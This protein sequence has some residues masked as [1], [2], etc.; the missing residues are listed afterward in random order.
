MNKIFIISGP[1]AVGKTSIAKAIIKKLP[2][3]Q[4]AVSFTTRQ[5]RAGTAEDKIMKYVTEKKFKAKIKKGDFIEWAKVHN[6]LY[7]TDK[8]IFS[9]LLKK[10][11][12]LL[13]IDVQGALQIKK[14][15]KNSVLI[16]IKPQSLAI[17]KKRIIK[18]AKGK[19][20]PKDFATRIANVKKELKFTEY[21]DYQVINRQGKLKQTLDSV[22]KII[23][24]ETKS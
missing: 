6:D 19:I 4:K 2:F 21:Y 12:V 23:Q 20:N 22:A 7:G 16:F 11:P 13:N 3:L 24:K 15:F 5:K 8:K 14:K 10:G 17:L 18:R 9:Q 1:V